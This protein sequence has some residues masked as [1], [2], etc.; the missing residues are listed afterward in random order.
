MTRKGQ[1]HVDVIL[2]DFAK[3]FDKV[4]HHRLLHKLNYYGVQDSTLRW[5][6]SFLCQRKQSVSLDVTKSSEAD[7]LSGVPQGTAL[8]PLLFLAFINDIPES[9]KHS[10][11]RLLRTASSTD[12][13]CQA[14]TKPSSRK[15]YLHWRDGKKTWQLKFHPDKCMVTRISTNR[16]QIL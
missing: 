12:M 3:A 2:L 10:D 5:M 16:K 11:A 6:E 7:V 4:P 13:S 9:T 8:R 1:V 14:K 15:T